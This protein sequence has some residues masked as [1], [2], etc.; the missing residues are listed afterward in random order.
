[1]LQDRFAK[2]VKI[3]LLNRHTVVRNA[4]DAAQTLLDVRWPTSGPKYRKAVETCLRI[5]ERRQGDASEGQKT[6][7]AAAHE[8]G[9]LAENPG[10][11]VYEAFSH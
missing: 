3:V 7:A 4:R 11:A 5:L 9:I 2:P 8:A 6:F 10:E 1:M